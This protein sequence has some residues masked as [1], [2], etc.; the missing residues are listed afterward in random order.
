M[1][2]CLRTSTFA[3]S[4]DSV[5]LVSSLKTTIKNNN[6][7]SQKLTSAG[8]GAQRG[9]GRPHRF[10]ATERRDKEPAGSVAPL[11]SSDRAQSLG[12]IPVFA[13]HL[14]SENA[15]RPPTSAM[16]SGLMRLCPDRGSLNAWSAQQ[17]NG[18]PVTTHACFMLYTD[19]RSRSPVIN[20]DGRSVG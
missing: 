7:A 19:S 12:A 1:R 13:A 5:R 9:H 15:T 10:R 20:S 2:N 4:Y 18:P 11:L 14:G 16:N 8:D 3:A 17:R 6:A